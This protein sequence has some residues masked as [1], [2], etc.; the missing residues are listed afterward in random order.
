[1]KDEDFA[2]VIVGISFV[3]LGLAYAVW[4]SFSVFFVALL[5]EFDW[6]RSVTAGAFSV[7][8]ILHGL[9]GP[10]VGYV[11]DR[12]GPRRV[13]VL[14]SLLLGAGLALCSVIRTWWHFYLF[15]GVIT[16]VG[17]GSAGWVPNVTV[18]QQWF[19]EKKGLPFGIISAGIGTGILVCV[20]LVQYL[21]SRVGWRM[22]YRIMSV[23]IPFTTISLAIT[24]LRR[25]P[26]RPQIPAIRKG[27]P[28]AV[29]ENPLVVD[30]EWASR[31]WSVR[32][33]MNTKQFWFVGLAFLLANIITHSILAHHVAFFVDQGLE[34]QF[35]SYVV[36]MVGIA[37]IGGKI[38]W[39]TLSDRIGREQV[40]TIGISCSACGMIVLILFHLFHFSI[41][42]YLYAVFFGLGYAATA[43]LPPLIVADLFQGPAF[44]GIFG[45]VMMFVG[46]GGAFGAWFAGFLFDRVGSYLPLLIIIIVVLAPLSCFNMWKAA[47]GKIRTVPGKRPKLPSPALS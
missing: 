1:M 29:I 44:G 45:S 30:E 7:F 4:Y 8:I 31:S 37:S 34:I 32:Q 47:P 18:I 12:L 23:A 3:T 26:Q 46:V 11:V 28:R 27:I 24:L 13:I 41:S 40:Y 16:A 6:S 38:L 14:G 25:S 36:G 35:A 39:G 17:V 20:P 43:S 15:F 22:A 9:A 33:A 10:F 42:P 21:I 2:W 5:R 19:K